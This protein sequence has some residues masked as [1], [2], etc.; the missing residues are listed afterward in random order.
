MREHCSAHAHVSVG[1]VRHI[2][3]LMGHFIPLL[4][5]GTH[6][7]M[8]LPPP[9]RAGLAKLPGGD[10]S[11]YDNRDVAWTQTKGFIQPQVALPNPNAVACGPRWISAR[12]LLEQHI[13][14]C[15]FVHHARPPT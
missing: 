15:I 8:Q 12:I 13:S 1:L 14:C 5:D 6:I 7:C 2:D 10:F 11:A 3:S 9:E 4:S